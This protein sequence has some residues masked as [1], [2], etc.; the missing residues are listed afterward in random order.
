MTDKEYH[1]AIANKI[2]NALREQNIGKK[3]FAQII[4]VTPSTVTKW[5]KGNHNFTV[6]TIWNIEHVLGITIIKLN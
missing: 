2:R 6:N 3:Q 4:G 1:Q 5:L